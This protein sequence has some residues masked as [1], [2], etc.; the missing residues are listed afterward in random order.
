MTNHN[1]TRHNRDK[2]GQCPAPLQ[3]GKPD[4]NSVLLQNNAP[5]IG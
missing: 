3:A 5:N 1:A 2:N 4:D